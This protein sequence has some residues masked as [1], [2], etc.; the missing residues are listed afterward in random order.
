MLPMKHLP[1]LPCFLFSFVFAH[2]QTDTLDL[3]LDKAALDM[4]KCRKYLGLDS[5]R[6][7]SSPPLHLW[8]KADSIFF[9]RN[10][11]IYVRISENGHLRIEGLKV[12]GEIAGKTLLYDKKGALVREE[13]RGRLMSRE[14][15]D[16]EYVA[17]ELPSCISVTQYR[18]GL[19]VRKKDRSIVWIEG[20]G[21]GVS[22]VRSF[23]RKGELTGTRETRKSYT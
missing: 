3:D 17:D 5:Y 8:T 2:A 14:S 1:I 22:T 11:S 18:K 19:I 21:W 9:E 10:D 13:L 20:K 23:Y 12:Y 6:K 4:K 15:H 16:G 7:V